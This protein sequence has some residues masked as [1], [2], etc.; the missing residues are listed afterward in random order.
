MSIPTV[1]RPQPPETATR[2]ANRQPS[3]IDGD[4][5]RTRAACRSADPELFTQA[6]NDPATELALSYCARGSAA[7]CPVL[8]QCRAA[9]WEFGGQG[10]WG[11][12]WRPLRDTV[13]SLRTVGYV[14]PVVAPRR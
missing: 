4:D 13:R 5:W 1:H 2:S 9:A 12:T 8:A 7:E 6:E 3:G 14:S 11:G 10:V